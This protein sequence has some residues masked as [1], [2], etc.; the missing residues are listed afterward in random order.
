VSSPSWA[1]IKRE[2]GV[3]LGEQLDYLAV[4]LSPE[5]RVA[6]RQTVIYVVIVKLE[7]LEVGGTGTNGRLKCV[8]PGG[9]AKAAVAAVMME[10]L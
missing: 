8:L 2:I 5:V 3:T 7:S 6:L 10:M 4:I 9:E 1:N